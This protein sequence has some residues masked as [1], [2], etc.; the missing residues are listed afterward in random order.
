MDQDSLG[1]NVPIDNGQL[2]EGAQVE[3]WDSGQDEDMIESSISEIDALTP[4]GEPTPDVQ[5]PFE[6]LDEGSQMD[7]QPGTRKRNTT[8]TVI[9]VVLLLVICCCCLFPLIFYFYLGD[10]L[11]EWFIDLITNLSP[12]MVSAIL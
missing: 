12:W 9:L 8:L 7:T 1:N 5:T 2:E 11:Y 6:I 10:P 3:I 4:P